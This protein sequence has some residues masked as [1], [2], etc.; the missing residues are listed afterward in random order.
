MGRSDGALV[1]D[2]PAF[3]MLIPHIMDRRCDSTNFVKVEIDMSNLQAYLRE[4]RDKGYRVGIMDAIIAAFV[5]MLKK[6]PEINRF[7]ANKR[8]YQRNHICVSFAMIK[9]G[10]DNALIETVIKVY[11]EPDD[12]LIA[13]SHKIRAAIKENEAPQ[14]KNTMDHFVDKLAMLPFLPGFLVWMMKFSD[15]HGFLPKKII[16][17]SPFHTSMFISNLASLRMGYV[18]HHLY[19]FGT[20]SLFVTLGKPKRKPDAGSID[21]KPKQIMTLGIA[22]DERICIGAIWAKAF[23]EFRKCIENPAVLMG[24]AKA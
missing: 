22:I 21:G 11:I 8:I 3:D 5:F 13:I 23:F 12:D 24:D 20:T 1:K 7:V 14:V 17:L 9:R 6:R 18:Y 2:I 15:K 4:L 16:K 19:E 10:M